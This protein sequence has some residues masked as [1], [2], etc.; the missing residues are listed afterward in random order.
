MIRQIDEKIAGEHHI[1]SNYPERNIAE[2]SATLSPHRPTLTRQ[3][4]P[5]QQPKTSGVPIE[6]HAT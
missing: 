6:P 2:T 3:A 1:K 5:E 4:P